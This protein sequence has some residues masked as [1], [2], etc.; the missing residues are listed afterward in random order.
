M[1]FIPGV[2]AV[3][4]VV[5]R[6]T[7]E[8]ARVVTAVAETDL[9]ILPLLHFKLSIRSDVLKEGPKKIIVHYSKMRLLTFPDIGNFSRDTIEYLELVT[10]I[11]QFNLLEILEVISFD[12]PMLS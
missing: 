10:K 7:A 8:C 4:D 6:L 11:G 3:A 9:L 12:P 1:L 2:V 5:S